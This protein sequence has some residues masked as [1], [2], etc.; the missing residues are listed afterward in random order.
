MLCI[1]IYIYI[2]ILYSYTDYTVHTLSQK[3]G[4]LEGK[5]AQLSRRKTWQG[6]FFDQADEH[7]DVAQ[8]TGR[9]CST[10]IYWIAGEYYIL[11]NTLDSAPCGSR[12]DKRI[13]IKDDKRLDSSTT[14]SPN[15]KAQVPSYPRH[16]G[17]VGTQDSGGRM[18]LAENEERLLGP[19][20]DPSGDCF[21]DGAFQ[22]RLEMAG[23][24]FL[25]AF[26]TLVYETLIFSIH[27]N[28]TSTK[29]NAG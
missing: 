4:F 11:W 24:Y 17:P 25:L 14:P 27:K 20:D 19:Y 23:D 1:Y 10:A 12:Q 13:L 7:C 2:Y 15:H 6:T 22:S 28:P 21:W 16:E 26:V 8:I 29:E 9:G 3:V 18:I 5:H